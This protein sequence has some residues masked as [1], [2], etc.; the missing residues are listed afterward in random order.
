MNRLP[1]VGAETWRLP[2]HAHFVVYET[3][4]GNELITIYD[5][6]AAQKPPRAQVIGNLVRVRTPHELLDQPTGYIVKLRGPALL[7]RQ[8]ADHW[9]VRERPE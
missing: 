6:G 1:S 4:D 5:C 2:Q 7:E 3:S 9:L 8:D